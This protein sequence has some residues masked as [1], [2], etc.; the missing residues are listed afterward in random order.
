MTKFLG[1]LVAITSISVASWAQRPV[2]RIVYSTDYSCAQLQASVRQH[3]EVIIYQN[4]WIYDRHVVH[5]GH[6][7]SGTV[8]RPSSIAARDTSRCFAGYIC[9]QD[10]R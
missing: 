8:E 10:P 7:W 4:R 9:V 3:K 2:Q 1:A 6:C 5:G